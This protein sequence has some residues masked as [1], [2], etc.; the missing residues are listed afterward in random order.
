MNPKKK[1]AYTVPKL[2]DFSASALDEAV[3]NL[4]AAVVRE[5]G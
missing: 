5:A 1:S 3:Q 2:K 4:L